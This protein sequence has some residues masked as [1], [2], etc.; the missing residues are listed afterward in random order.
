MTSTLGSDV[1]ADLQCESN[2]RRRHAHTISKFADRMVRELRAQKLGLLDVIVD[3]MAGKLA[4]MCFLVG[5][6]KDKVFC[7]TRITRIFES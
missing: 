7:T 1:P 4:A 5:E 3:Q 2:H 6:Q